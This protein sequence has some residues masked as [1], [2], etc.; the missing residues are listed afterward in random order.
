MNL[1]PK[2][3]VL[4]PT[5]FSELASSVQKLTLQFVENPSHLYVIHVL[6]P[7]SPLEPGIVWETLDDNTRKLNVEKTFRTKFTTPEYER[8]NF[9]VLFGEPSKKIISYAEEKDIELIVIPAH[10]HNGLKS[11]LLGSVTERVVRSARCPVYVW[12]ST[13]NK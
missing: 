6:P 5:D 3:R 7:L 10:G 4:F 11:F 13:E 1:I 8:V 9:D 2:N 12:R